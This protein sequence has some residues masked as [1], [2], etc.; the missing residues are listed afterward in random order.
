MAAVRCRKL[1]VQE[2]MW[3][4]EMRD[5]YVG[6]D[7]AWT[8]NAAK[9]GAVTALEIDNGRITRFD[10]PVLAT[11]KEAGDYIEQ[12]AGDADYVLIALDQPTLVP[13]HESCRPV[14]RVA[15]SVVNRIGGGVQP[16]NRSKETMFGDAAP[17]WPFLERLGARENPLAAREATNGRFLI[18]VF[19]A[20]ALPSMIGA[21]W[22]RK[23][24]A[25]YNPGSRKMFNMS[26]WLLVAN[27]V[28]DFASRLGVDHVAD[29]AKQFAVISHPTKSDQDRLDALICLV[30]ALAWRMDVQ[31]NSAVI[32]DG[33]SGYM[34]TPV[35]P[36]T[37]AVI[38]RKARECGVQV[39]TEWLTDARRSIAASS[40]P[41]PAK[42]KRT[43]FQRGDRV[44][45]LP[46]QTIPKPLSKSIVDD[47][48][49]RS[50][51][52]SAANERRTVTYGEVAGHF[53]QPW[54]RGF[55]SS[56]N[57]ALNRLGEENR[58]SGE[59]LLMALVVNA[60]QGVPGVGYYR[61]AGVEHLPEPERRQAHQEELTA[62]WSF[63]WEGGGP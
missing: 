54:S 2:Q 34:V 39:D 18:E 7:S 21:I 48:L 53:G 58:A 63:F 47:D 38:T 32:G 25:K 35:S 27:G 59:P 5:C 41:A 51:L 52:I 4:R 61:S 57:S 55:G 28:A 9:P 13:N 30:V 44:R 42:S 56:L 17:V 50:F 24:A 1:R 49:L 10:S 23:R 12:R 36:E 37:R 15:G 22:G 31:E 43:L 3:G 6:F 33:M 19:P 40:V 16:A 11:F 14:D 29:A 45:Q 20:L 26:D 46:L 8:D 60:D 62:I